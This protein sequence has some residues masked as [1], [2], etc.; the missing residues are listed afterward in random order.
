MVR[1]M[2]RRRPV[3]WIALCVGVALLL[4]SCFGGGG[5]TELVTE[6]EPTPEPLYEPAGSPGLASFFPLDEQLSMVSADLAA[7]VANQQ[8][9]ETEDGEPGAPSSI[10]LVGLGGPTE[11]EVKTGLYGGTAE[12][13]CDPERLIQYLIDNP[14]KGQVWADVQGIKFVEIPDYIRSLEAEVLTEDRLVLN[15]GFDPKGHAIPIVSTLAA[16]TAVLVDDNGDV[17]TRCYC[18]NP[19]LPYTPTTYMPPNCLSHYAVVYTAPNDPKVIEGVPRSVNATLQIANYE[20]IDWKE[21]SWGGST[22][23]VRADEATVRYCKP[24]DKPDC[25]SFAQVVNRPGSQDVIGEIDKGHISVLAGNVEGWSLVKFADRSGW[26][27]AN[28]MGGQDCTYDVKC[29]AVSTGTWTRPG[30]KGIQLV[31]NGAAQKIELTGQRYVDQTGTYLQAFVTYPA[32]TRVGY[33]D[34]AAVTEL[35]ATDCKTSTRCSHFDFDA[36]VY[37]ESTGTATYGTL[38]FAEVDIIS[39]PVNNRYE[40]DWGTATGWVEVQDLQGADCVRYRV[41]KCVQIYQTVYDPLPPNSSTRTTPSGPVIVTFT[42]KTHKDSNNDTYREFFSTAVPGGNAWVDASFGYNALPYSA[43][44]V[45]PPCNQEF[46]V[47]EP[48]CITEFN[49]ADGTWKATASWQPAQS[50]NIDFVFPPGLSGSLPAGIYPS[51]VSSIGTGTPSDPNNLT[52]TL[53]WQDIF[54]RTGSVDCQIDPC[55]FLDYDGD[56]GFPE[57]FPRPNPETCIQIECSVVLPLPPATSDTTVTVNW[58]PPGRILDVDFDWPAPTPDDSFTNVG[59]G[60]SSTRIALNTG[61]VIVLWTADDGQSGTLDCDIEPVCRDDVIYPDRGVVCCE[62]DDPP[63]P[64]TSR[65]CVNGDVPLEDGS[66]CCP[67]EE[68]TDGICCVQLDGV[69]LTVIDGCSE[70]PPDLVELVTGE[71]CAEELTLNLET[72]CTASAPPNRPAGICGDDD[73][74]GEVAPN[75]ECCVDPRVVVNNG[76][77]LESQVNGAGECCPDGQQPVGERCGPICR[78]GQQPNGDVCECPQGT[79]DNGDECVENPPP[80]PPTCR[81]D[82]VLTDDG[83]CVCPTG[84]QDNGS[85]CVP[86]CPAGQ[87]L[88]GGQCVVVCGV[89]EVPN[90]SGSCDPVCPDGTVDTGGGCGPTCP[91]GANANGDCFRICAPGEL[92]LDGL[93]ICADGFQLDGI[94]GCVVSCPGNQI[95][96]GD[97]CGCPQGSVLEGTS[98]VDVVDTPT[99]AAPYIAEGPTF[100]Y[101]EGFTGSQSCPATGGPTPN[102]ARVQEVINPATGLFDLQVTCDYA[103]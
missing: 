63:L 66:L 43:C 22:G 98:C 103:L 23:W 76:C 51:S 48:K 11:D 56:F 25:V 18:G 49:R 44:E 101:Y 100:C 9:G 36:T 45:D 71:C 96:I 7:A 46:Q 3:V 70:C 74:D 82:Q 90:S 13:T 73:C 78:D 24:V 81:Q 29:V 20:G 53:N 67:S 94:N 21:I 31:G 64:G 32:P 77:C 55:D 72:C 60:V 89:D 54:G 80:P 8:P 34:A 19:I 75:G 42:G 68:Y 28:Q 79:T 47:C 93:C 91:N 59:T 61:S 6:A 69:N 15:H 26:I 14:D 86:V 40:I 83:R 87:T 41:V 10:T 62:E 5:V 1:I 4:S 52:V 37:E 30:L 97:T 16:G 17:R 2:S 65:C 58:T 57:G 27:Q 12:N 102:L 33:V 92:N 84:Q 50:L 39:G 99:C 95:P 38:W 88:Q 35:P 85:S